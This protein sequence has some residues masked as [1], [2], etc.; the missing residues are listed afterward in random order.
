MD[1]KPKKKKKKEEATLEEKSQES[2]V[3]NNNSNN[4][5][6]YE[7]VAHIEETD[8]KSK[9]KKKS[10]KGSIQLEV[11]AEKEE[12]VD[13]EIKT[14]TDTVVEE[15]V[16]ETVT[17]VDNDNVVNDQNETVPLVKSDPQNGGVETLVDVKETVQAEVKTE[18]MLKKKKKSKKDSTSVES[19]AG[20][21]ET[22]DEQTEEIVAGK[23]TDLDVNNSIGDQSETVPVVVM[24]K[25][26]KKNESFRRVVSESVFVP[27]QLQDNSFRHEKKLKR[28]EAVTAVATLIPLLTLSNLVT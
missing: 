28:N 5:I 10:K 21:E 17:D 20:K 6:E 23:D 27:E 19:N 8:K 18:K 13:K 2:E 22:V 4:I 24:S 14:E 16:I 12:P 25:K 26:L 1:I 9:K 11:P 7:K 3:H 15:K